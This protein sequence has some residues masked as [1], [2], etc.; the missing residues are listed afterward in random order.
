MNGGGKQVE[1]SN[2]IYHSGRRFLKQRLTRQ[3]EIRRRVKT[4]ISLEREGALSLLLTKVK[5]NFLA[6]AVQRVTRNARSLHNRFWTIKRCVQSSQ[7]CSKR[8]TLTLGNKKTGHGPHGRTWLPQDTR[9][10]QRNI[11]HGTERDILRFRMSFPVSLLE[12]ELC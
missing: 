9:S 7:I 3:L 1:S 12:N 5:A 6:K 11:W 2:R 10:L 8:A 4:R